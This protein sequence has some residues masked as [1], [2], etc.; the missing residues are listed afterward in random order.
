MT[1]P[2]TFD[3]HLFVFKKVEANMVLD[4]VELNHVEF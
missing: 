4:E 1:V 3:Y 2:W